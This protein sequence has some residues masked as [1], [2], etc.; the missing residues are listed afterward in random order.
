MN[1]EVVDPREREEERRPNPEGEMEAVAL[2]EKDP[3]RTTKPAGESLVW[4]I[5][6]DGSSGKNGSGVGVTILTPE[7]IAVEQALQL[8]FK[9]TNNQAEYEALI[10]GLRLAKELGAKQATVHSDSQLSVVTERIPKEE[11]ERADSLSKLASASA[12]CGANPILK[13]ALEAP[14]IDVPEELLAPRPSAPPEEPL[15]VPVAPQHQE[16]KAPPSPWLLRPPVYLF[17]V[18]PPRQQLFHSRG[19]TETKGKAPGLAP[20]K[21]SRPSY[22]SG[23]SSWE[24]SKGPLQRTARIVVP[25]P[26]HGTAT[27]VRKSLHCLPLF[28]Q[29]ILQLDIL[30]IGLS[31]TSATDFPPSEHSPVGP[32]ENARLSGEKPSQASAA[33]TPFP[34]QEKLSLSGYSL[35]IASLPLC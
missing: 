13:A 19:Q 27:I 2:A 3:T 4:T 9:T 24:A 17:P 23:E 10:A 18:K 31:G 8:N 1:A 29:G 20:R 22:P 34:G 12:R 32:S 35:H 15:G 33:P 14:S 6:V 25:S 21:E 16:Q 28:L 7:G 5:F 11:N 30:T 26:L